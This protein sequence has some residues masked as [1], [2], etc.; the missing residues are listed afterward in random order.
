MVLITRSAFEGRRLDDGRQHGRRWRW[1]SQGAGVG[2]S[3]SSVYVT[4]ALSPSPMRPLRK[5]P[6]VA[7]ALTAVPGVYASTRRLRLS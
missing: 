4:E 1:R 7:R 6:P 3:V 2:V 5:L